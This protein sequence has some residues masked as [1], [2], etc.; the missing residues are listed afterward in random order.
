MQ[1]QGSN[2]EFQEKL[3]NN[4]VGRVLHTPSLDKQQME[5]F[6]IKFSPV[7]SQ[8]IPRP[9][10]RLIPEANPADAHRA[11]GDAGGKQI[12]LHAPHH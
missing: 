5:P 4:L 9:C 11:H 6:A 7:G 12:E 10:H 3:Q 1:Q 2:I 8:K